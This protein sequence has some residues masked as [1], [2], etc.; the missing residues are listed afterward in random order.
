MVHQAPTNITGMIFSVIFKI[1]H[2]LYMSATMINAIIKIFI[3]E[4]IRWSSFSVKISH[5]TS[6]STPYVINYYQIPKNI[7]VKVHN[8]RQIII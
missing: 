8:I 2:L 6:N 1:L 5:N 3:K 4:S 7:F